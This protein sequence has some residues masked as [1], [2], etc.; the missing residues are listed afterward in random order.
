MKL[1]ELK[2]I[3]ELSWTKE[4]CVES[5]KNSW[6]SDNK[7][8]GQCAITAL[9]VN[10][11]MGG[12][13][14]KCMCE[15]GSH[16]Y[17][18]INDNIIDLTVNQFS[19]L[20]KYENSEERTVEYILSYEET[21]KRYILLLKNIKENFDKFGSKEYK[22]IDEFGQ[23]Y[24]SKIPGSIGGHKKLKIYGKM[25]CKSALSWIEKG[26]YINNRVFFENEFIAI[27]NGYRPCAKCMKK[28][29]NE[30]KNKK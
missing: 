9:I 13:I 25:D 1:E 23:T 12:K 2:R 20:P 6:S 30:W 24:L 4:T 22:L 17:N 29:Y 18:V 10:L 26:H 21:K 11:Y 3:I 27:K 14:M 5:L 7:S 16:Y 15:S 19:V 8:L 28:E